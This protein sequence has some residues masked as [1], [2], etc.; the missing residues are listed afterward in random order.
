V[1]AHEKSKVTNP[2]KFHGRT[3]REKRR[4]RFEKQLLH[5]NLGKVSITTKMGRFADRV[6]LSLTIAAVKHGRKGWRHSW[7]IQRVGGE[8]GKSKGLQHGLYHEEGGL[9]EFRLLGIS[10]KER[11]KK[12]L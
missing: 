1:G 2:T 4:I 5:K 3:K 10:K 7:K 11:G 8:R 6:C 9:P 12:G